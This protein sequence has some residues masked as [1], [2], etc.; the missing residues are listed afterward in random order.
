MLAENNGKRDT[1]AEIVC[2]NTSNPDYTPNFWTQMEQL[3][4]TD[5]DMIL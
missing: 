4:I 5:E 1:A 3:P 2:H